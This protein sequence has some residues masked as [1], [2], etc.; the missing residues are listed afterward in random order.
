MEEACFSWDSTEADEQGKPLQAIPEL[1][2]DSY[3]Q[4]RFGSIDSFVVRMVLV[5]RESNQ[6]TFNYNTTKNLR[7]L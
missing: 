7:L 5:C 2:K 1:G 6:D 3:Q 4:N